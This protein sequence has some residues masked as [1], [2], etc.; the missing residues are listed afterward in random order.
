MILSII[1]IPFFSSLSIFLFGRY[2]GQK[3]SVYISII[4]IMMSMILGIRQLIRYLKYNE[5]ITINIYDWINTGMI[6]ISLNLIID[7]YSI[8]MIFLITTITFIVITYSTWYMKEDAHK[9]RFLSI[10]L[11]FAVT[12]LILVSSSNFLL[13][14]IGWEG[15]GIMSY[16]LINFW[17]FSINSN[18]SAI[19]AILYNKLG[20]IG[21]LMGISMMILLLSNTTI[22]NLVY[23]PQLLHSHSFGVDGGINIEQPTVGNI[24]IIILL[25]FTIAS[26]AKSAQILLHPWL[27]DAMAGPTPVS[28]LLHA[29]TMVTAGVFLLLRLESIIYI[30]PEIRLIIITVGLITIIFGGLS[31]INQNDIKKIIAFSTCSQL[32]Y[33]FLTNGLLLPSVGLYHLLT[34]G[35]FKAM[36]FLTAGIIIHNFK[37]EQDIRKFGSFVLSFP[38]SFFLFLLGSL[39]ILSFPFLSGF[40]SK[41]AIIESSL[42]PQ[43]PIY[44]Y[45]IMVIGGM[46]T[47]IYSFKLLYYTFFAK[48]NSLNYSLFYNNNNIHP[49]FPLSKLNILIFGILILGSIFFG[50][51]SKELLGTILLVSDNEFFPYYIKLIPLFGSFL[52]IFLAFI[53]INPWN[54]AVG[55][56]LTI[57]NRRFFFDSLINYFFAFKSLNFGYLYT[58]KFLD[59]GFFELFG[60][61]GLL[62]LLYSLPLFYS[63]Y[64]EKKEHVQISVTKLLE[65][66]NQSNLFIYL[67]FTFLS[68]ILLF[69]FIQF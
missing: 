3:G 8:L 27:G 56:I 59:R 38:F 12:M 24:I 39:S 42:S 28:A 61:L 31:S 58:F 52:G 50:Y 20:D 60:P 5:E 63:K 15:V 51:I 1:T 69:F 48:P 46:L 43:Y 44:V 11:M 41:E 22:N 23:L 29:A 55:Y 6:K 30:S 21:F 64:G 10:L 32:G 57:M 2:I 16:L 17:Y 54:K 62:R 67:F 37:N 49:E 66:E 25:L 4:S 19:K 26:I 68:L 35:F 13:M 14:F 34:H 53:I 18:K 47:S 65:N 7:K 33:M 45:I 36:L 40:Y 9:N